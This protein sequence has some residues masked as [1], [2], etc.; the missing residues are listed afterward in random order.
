M[1][2]VAKASFVVVFITE[3]MRSAAFAQAP[4]TSGCTPQERSNWTLRNSDQKN[5][6]VICPPNV[7]PA[8]KAPTPKT[9]D[10]PAIPLPSGPGG[11]RSEQPA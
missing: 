6:D 4:D 3:A 9:G 8:I 10:P 1:N 2:V 5:A 7:D 11:H